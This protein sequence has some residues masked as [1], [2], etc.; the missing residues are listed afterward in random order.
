MARI[1]VVDDERS[2]CMVI[3]AHLEQ[4]GHAVTACTD[5][6]LAIRSILDQK[7]DLVLLD[8][9][10]PYIDGFEMLKALRGDPLTRELP[11]IVVSSRTDLESLGRVAALRANGFVYKPVRGEA[12]VETVER[13]LAKN[14]A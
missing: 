4:A 8:L 2:M 11:V 5:G 9:C 13:V 1:L 12:L 3:S 6:A 14:A 7:P 10:M